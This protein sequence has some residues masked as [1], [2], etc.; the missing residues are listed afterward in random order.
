MKK[1]IDFLC[2][3]GPESLGVLV[4]IGS[5]LMYRSM[6]LVK[7]Y[8]HV[9]F[10]DDLPDHLEGFRILQISDL[11][12]RSKYKKT[13]DIWKHVNKLDFDMVAITGDV[14]LDE[15]SE[16]F[17]H[18]Q[19]IS[20]LAKNYPTF[21]IEG[22][23]EM[24]YSFDEFKRFFSS[25]GV[26]VLDNQAYVLKVTGGELDVL[27]T[28]DYITLLH[29]GKSGFYDIFRPN[30]KS[31]NFQL[32]LTHQPQTIH[33]FDHTGVDFVLSGHTHGGQIRLP[34]LPTIYAP[35]Q[36]FFP[37][38]G[39][40]F[41]NVNGIVLY[42]SRGIGATTFPFRLFN[43]PEITVFELQKNPKFLI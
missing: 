4:A 1:I 20:Q 19:E 37:K 14:I 16:I 39:N 17:P 25:L 28:R 6:R 18:A 7:V 10:F 9:V 2:T 43:R 41:Y 36:G 24:D 42:V 23:H 32:V 33:W 40:G 15:I 38:F 8:E 30:R 21:F 26:K 13:I 35:L 29:N 31:D 11:H 5:I 34:F 22:N 27:G 3:K 12:N